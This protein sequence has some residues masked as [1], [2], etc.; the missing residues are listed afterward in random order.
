[1]AHAL[2]EK[3][4]VEVTMGCGCSKPSA[5]SPAVRRVHPGE[6]V[7]DQIDPLPRPRP[8]AP[9]PYTY[10]EPLPLTRFYLLVRGLIGFLGE[11]R[12]SRVAKAQ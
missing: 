11:S 9:D 4:A 3:T 1:M 12:E 5:G 2:A 7:P 8:R 6:V 10:P